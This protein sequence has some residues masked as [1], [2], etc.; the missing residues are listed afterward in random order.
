[1]LSNIQMELLKL[2]HTNLSEQELKQLKIVLAKFFADKTIREA[3][4]IW[5]EKNY[6]EMT[7]ENWLNEK[8]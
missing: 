1:M 6:S 8:N 3:D 5:E 4:K 2:Y 7:M